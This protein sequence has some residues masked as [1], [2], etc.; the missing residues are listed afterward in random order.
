M[1][2][3]VAKGRGHLDWTAVVLDILEDAGLK[4][5]S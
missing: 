1:V 5:G 4:P 2:A 3:G